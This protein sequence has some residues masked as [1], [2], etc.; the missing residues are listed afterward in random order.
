GGDAVLQQRL[1]QVERALDMVVKLEL[2][3]LQRATVKDG[4][5]DNLSADPLYVAAFRDYN[6]P[7]L[8]LEPDEAAER[9][10][11]SPISEQL[12]GALGDW[13][14]IKTDGAEKQKLA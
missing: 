7:V 1:N 2:A 3:R 5:F 14:N 9:I 6:L 8:D 11:A 10:A 13:A 4:H 12:L